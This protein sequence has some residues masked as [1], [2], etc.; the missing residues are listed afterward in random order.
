M[1]DCTKKNRK[2]SYDGLLLRLAHVVHI[3]S[4]ESGTGIMY[5]YMS[6]KFSNIVYYFPFSYFVLG[7][8]GD[9]RSFK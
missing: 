8:D 4:I 9:S 2:C 1:V 7:F 3:F 5:Q 6:H